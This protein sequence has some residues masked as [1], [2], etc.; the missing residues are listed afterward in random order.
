MVGR[1][2]HA[3]AAQ[4]SRQPAPDTRRQPH[5]LAIFSKRCPGV[6]ARL[7]ASSCVSKGDTELATRISPT[8]S[9]FAASTLQPNVVA[10]DDAATA[11]PLRLT[12]YTR[13]HVAIAS[14]LN[15]PGI[16][17]LK[18]EVVEAAAK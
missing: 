5:P 18:C 7:S 11:A 17:N 10:C 9:K 15:F 14:K 16:A 1:A 4:P 3:R 2:R 8:Y 12:T 13:N 6:A